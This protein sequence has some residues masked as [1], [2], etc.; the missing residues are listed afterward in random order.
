[1][2]DLDFR[3]FD[4]LTLSKTGKYKICMDG[5]TGPHK[6]AHVHLRAKK[7]RLCSIDISNGEL[8][9]GS[10]PREINS[11]LEAWISKHRAELI[12]AWGEFQCGAKPEPIEWEF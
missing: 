3:I 7:R 1:M 4:E 5:E 6:A 8:L 2:A 12:E 9:A 10:I 11:K